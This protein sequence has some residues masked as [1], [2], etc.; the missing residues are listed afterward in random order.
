MQEMS[1]FSEQSLDAV[2]GTIKIQ[3]PGK[4]LL[5]EKNKEEYSKNIRNFL[6]GKMKNGKIYK[7]HELK[8]L[9][10][11]FLIEK[12]NPNSEFDILFFLKVNL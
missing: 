8:V 12:T 4:E 10:V 2:F 7:K 5:S 6:T 3:E 11:R 9:F 1:E